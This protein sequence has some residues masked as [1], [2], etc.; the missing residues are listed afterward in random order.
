MSFAL[1]VKEFGDKNTGEIYPR[2]DV[3]VLENLASLLPDAEREKGINRSL[4]E[5]NR[6]HLVDR[7]KELAKDVGLRVF[8]VS[9]VGTSQ[10]CSRCGTLGRRYSIRRST[11]THRP[12]IQFGFVEKLFACPEC[13][14]RANADHNASVNLHRRLAQVPRAFTQWEDLR[15]TSKDMQRK[16]WEEMEAK[17]LPSLN[18]MHGLDSVDDPHPSASS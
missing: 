5:F 1:N 8:E 3:L 7:V 2:A 14:Y 4:I 9:P 18:K 13:G 17:L 16:R 11:E 15:S 10:V 12:E 6:G